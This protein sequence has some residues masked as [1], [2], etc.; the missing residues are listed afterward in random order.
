MAAIDTRRALI[1]KQA[2]ANG[3]FR[4]AAESPARPCRKM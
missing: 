1:R 2:K 4:H 3:R